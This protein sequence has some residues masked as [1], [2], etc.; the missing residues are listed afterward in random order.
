MPKKSGNY[1]NAV[2][3][4]KEKGYDKGW[5]HHA[6]IRDGTVYLIIGYDGSG[7]DLKIAIDEVAFSDSEL[8]SLIN[9]PIST[10]AQAIVDNLNKISKI[11]NS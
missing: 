11:M 1:L 6:I 8:I 7:S 5:E 3:Y 4:C 2:D 10:E 9:G